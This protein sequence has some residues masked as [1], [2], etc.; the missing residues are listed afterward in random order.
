MKMALTDREVSAGTDPETGLPVI[1]LQ[2]LEAVDYPYPDGQLMLSKETARM[3]G[4]QLLAAADPELMARL[5]YTVARQGPWD[6]HGVTPTDDTDG[7]HSDDGGETWTRR[8]G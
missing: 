3:V 2:G 8:G 1:D 5:I 7:M 4:A 6:E